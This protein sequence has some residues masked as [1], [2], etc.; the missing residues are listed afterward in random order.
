MVV[1]HYL[2][3][4]WSYGSPRKK[5]KKRI[6]DMEPRGAPAFKEVVKMRRQWNVGGQR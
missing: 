6:K 5:K 2:R 1:S 4:S 3:G